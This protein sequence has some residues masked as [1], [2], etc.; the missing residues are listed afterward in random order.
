MP[1]R[2]WSARHQRL[3]RTAS[4]HGGG[5]LRDIHT[6]RQHVYVSPKTYE[7]GGRALV[8]LPVNQPLF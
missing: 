2:A 4:G 6:I 8:G 7:S 5:R 3:G 1:R